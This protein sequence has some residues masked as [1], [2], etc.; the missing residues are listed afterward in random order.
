MAQFEPKEGK[1]DLLFNRL[2]ALEPN[3][4]R[5]DGCIGYRVTKHMKNQFADGESMSI[6]FIESWRDVDAF[7]THCQRDEI[8]EF[9]E[10]ECLSKEGLVEKYNVTTYRDD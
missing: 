4:L 3:T 2:K 5:E 10:S 6:V 1:F 9:F 7:E 8:V